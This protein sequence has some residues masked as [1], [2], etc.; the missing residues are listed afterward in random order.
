[1]CWTQQFVCYCW[2][3]GDSAKCETWDI[4]RKFCVIHII[5]CLRE[6]LEWNT[7][8]AG[9]PDGNSL[10]SDSLFQEHFFLAL[11]SP[12]PF[13]NS[14]CLALRNI[15]RVLLALWLFSGG[16]LVQNVS[17]AHETFLLPTIF[18]NT[19]NRVKFTQV[20]T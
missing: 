19:L 7:R 6:D 18:W 16:L 5:Y 8:S 14:M 20:S 2:W 11:C 13:L 9:Q 3:R 4:Q 1:M 10:T 12:L 17:Q 15:S